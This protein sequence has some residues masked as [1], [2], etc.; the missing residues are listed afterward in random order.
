M[1]DL[2]KQIVPRA[3]IELAPDFAGIPRV[4]IVGA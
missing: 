3:K 2:A 4:L 1:I